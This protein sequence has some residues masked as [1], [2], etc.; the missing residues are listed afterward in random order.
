M[1]KLLHSVLVSGM[2]LGLGAVP[3]FASS[4]LWTLKAPQE[5][6]L[7]C[8][9]TTYTHT[10]KTISVGLDGSFTGTGVYNADSSYTWDISGKITGDAITFALVYTGT[11]PGYTLNGTG[12]M[13]PDGTITGTL[14]GNC[15]SFAMQA[16]TIVINEN[17]NNQNNHG[18]F[19]R[20]Q[21]DKR[22]AAQSR[23]GMPEQSK[24][25]T[26]NPGQLSAAV[27]SKGKGHLK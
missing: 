25:H 23:I 22:A 6:P 24:G 7:V 21:T 10:L 13:G 8:G 26:K 27:S 1:K 14:D 17:Q 9:G 3:V 5:I 20:S 19:V 18:Q 16:S 4:D 12:T 2:M 15:E 11:N